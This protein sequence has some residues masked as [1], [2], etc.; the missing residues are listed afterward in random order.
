MLSRILKAGVCE[1]TPDH[2]RRKIHVANS[3]A[4]IVGLGVAIP[5]LII[6]WIHFPPLVP[7]P[8]LG[9]VVSLGAISLNALGS[10]TLA[11]VIISLLPLMLAAT[12]NAG[13]AAAGEPP[14]LGVYMVELS[15]AITVF[16]V[17]DIREKGYLFSLAALSLLIIVTF[18]YT[19]QWWEPPLD[20]TII[21]EGYVGTIAIFIS[22][23]FAFGS[24]YTLVG[25][26]Q[27]SEKRTGQLLMMAQESNQ[28]MTQSEQELKESL[29]Q[30]RATQQEEKRRQWAT[31]GIA[32]I[33]GI[34]RDSDDFASMADRLIT[35]IV[36]YIEAN[37]G[38]LFVVEEEG[39]DKQ[40]K[41]Q[42]CYAYERKKFLEKTIAIGQG[43][44]GQAYLEQEYIYL[45]ELPQNYVN[46][47]SGLGQATPESL[48]IMPLIVNEEVEGLIEIASF[49]EFESY[50]IEFLQTLSENIAATLRNARVNAQTRV[51]LEET[52]QQAEEMRAQEEEMRQ[53]M[54][55]LQ[56]TQEQSERLRTELEESQNMLK[57]K[58]QE[59]EVAQ[60]E[61][62]E[63][64]RVEKQRADEQIQA[65][66]K[67][68]E[69]AMQKF[70]Q[71]E[72]DLLSQLEASKK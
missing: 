67:M 13:L 28:K 7:V 58:L 40:I 16:L 62:E 71:R 36:R 2:Q 44:I 21:R 66:T 51:L 54:E 32:K 68:M 48:I 65:R 38:G 27:L 26:N 33:G 6:S 49:R 53:N 37:Q 30:I 34:L 55:E 61:T 8:V 69:K 39:D 45:T 60:R 25:Q 18:H 12:Y 31:E 29:E 23:L 59:L 56:A 64:R 42:S 46:I 70:K 24:V 20:A 9:I 11:R 72:Q 41:L 10:T 3:V 35:H 43:L 17:F 22:I 52:Q 19:K 15:F 47:T 57:E 4:L 1:D 50:E 14:V 5:F 63:V